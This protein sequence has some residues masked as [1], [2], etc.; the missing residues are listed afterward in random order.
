MEQNIFKEARLAAGLTR[1]A[2]SELME[3]PLRTLENWESG[4]RIPP[5]YVER[6]VL[7]ELK[8]IESRN[9]SEWKTTKRVTTKR[10]I[11]SISIIYYFFDNYYVSRSY[12]D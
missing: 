4:N 5:K 7:K 11:I 8:E 6:W 3:I 10:T 12:N 1:V 2:M 9:Q